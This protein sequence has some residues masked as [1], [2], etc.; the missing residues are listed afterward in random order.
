MSLAG[1]IAAAYLSPLY[2]KPQGELLKRTDYIIIALRLLALYLFVMGMTGVPSTLAAIFSATDFSSKLTAAAFGSYI[3]IYLIAWLFIWFY[4]PKV[5]KLVEKDIPHSEGHE[6]ELNIPNVMSLGLV[7]LGFYVLT[8]A[9]PSFV[10]IIIAY[11][12]PAYDTEFEKMV[13]TFSGEYT[14]NVPWS[15]IASLIVQTAFSTWLILG[16]KG[17]VSFVMKVRFAGRPYN[18]S[19]ERDE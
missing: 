9:I 4:A 12:A 15:N 19:S 11:I 8:N 5:A 2:G 3:V 13:G 7:F 6:T 16:S 18:Q 14:A 17:I 10:Q 1:R